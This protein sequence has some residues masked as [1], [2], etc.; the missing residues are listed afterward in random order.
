MYEQTE[1][2]SD[3]STTSKLP[4]SLT[5]AS[6]SDQ[7]GLELELTGKICYYC[8]VAKPIGCFSRHANDKGVEYYN[9]R[10][11]QCRG[12]RQY[13][14]PKVLARKELVEKAKAKPCADCGGVFDPVSMDFDHVDG[15]RKFLVSSAWRWKST[16][17]I[18]EELKKCEVVCSNCH[19]VRTKVRK[20]QKGRKSRMTEAD[21]ADVPHVL[22][23][24]HRS[25]IES[26]TDKMI[27]SR[28]C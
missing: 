21:L 5:P 28:K 11:N 7:L 12:K 4:S 27:V 8:N 15:A 19:R 23:N 26:A 2:P 13:G 6:Q 17:A 16:E 24:S 1:K 3:D 18:E 10:C 9:R 20:Q 14:S 25:P 22:I